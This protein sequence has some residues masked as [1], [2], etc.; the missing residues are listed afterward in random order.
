MGKLIQFIFVI[1]HFNI[2]VCSS[3]MNTGHLCRSDQSQFL[4]RLK[5]RINID[6]TASLDCDSNGKP[7]YPKTIS[8]NRSTDCCR[9][10]GVTCNALSGEVIGLDLSCSQ[11]QGVI[12]SNS[13]L[14][15]LSHLQRLNLAY[16]D[17]SSSLIS[18]KFGGLVSLTH[19][20]LSSSGFSG[21]LPSQFL[22]LSHL[23]SLDL[24]LPSQNI[25]I[26]PTVF[27]L[28][29]QN[30]TQLREVLLTGID[31]ASV[32]PSNLSASLAALKLGSTNLYGKCPADI[33]QL[34]NLLR[35]E[36]HSNFDLSGYLS[37]VK[38]NR[39][40]AL[41]YLDLSGTAF[42]G[43][44][45]ESIGHLKSLNNLDLSFCNFWGPIPESLANLTQMDYLLLFGNN[46]SGQVPSRLG[47]LKQLIRLDLST[48]SL[49]GQMPNFFSSFNNLQELSLS[50]NY[51]IGSFP[52]SVINLTQ[53]KGLDL[54]NNSLTGPIPSNITGLQNLVLLLLGSNLLSGAAPS[55]AFSLPSLIYLDL[56]LNQLTGQLYDFQYQPLQRIYL[57]GNQ[58]D[59]PVPKSI[60]KLVNLTLLDLS[61]N[62]FSGVLDA[63]MFSNCNQLGTLDLSD[64][65]LLLT[66]D[67]VNSSLPQ[68]LAYLFLSS[69]GIKDLDFLMPVNS[70]YRLDLSKN[71]LRGQLFSD[72]KWSNW[73]QH[74]YYLNLS[75][76]FLIDVRQ[77]PFQNLV[78]LDLSS[79]LLQGPLLIP[80][81]TTSVFVI[82]DNNLTGAIPSTICTLS[83]LVILDLSNNNF[84]GVIPLCLG[85]MSM[86]LSVLDMHKNR[87]HGNIPLIFSVGSKLRSLNLRD[88]RLE[89]AVPRSLSNCQELEV[90]DMGNNFLNGTFPWWLGN[91][92]HLRVLSLRSNNLGGPVSTPRAQLGSFSALRILDL[93]QN[94]FT[95]VLPARIFSQLNDMKTINGATRLKYLGDIMY[96]DSV[97]LVVKG[98]EINLV[99][100]LTIFT[101]ID[102][103]SNKFEG[104]IP[105]VIGDLKS[106]RGL[107]F[108]H[109]NL[110]G[111][112]PQVLG[113]LTILESLDLSSNQLVGEIPQQLTALTY[114]S[115]L[116]LSQNHLVG[117]IPRGKQF[118]T[119]QNNSY[120]GNRALCGFPLSK[121]CNANELPQ[122]QS[123]PPSLDEEDNEEL[124]SGFTWSAVLIG[125]GCGMV[126]G[127][128]TGCLIFYTGRPK[129]FCKIV[130]RESSKL[131]KKKRPK[132]VK[133]L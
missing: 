39:C 26:Q 40:S 72:Q 2:A 117:S 114:L 32:I 93:S 94:D 100:I 73:S 65:N 88:N 10:D 50:S 112:I 11:L 15:Q 53:L 109:N 83:S 132:Y 18:S 19:L 6:H 29:L 98:H 25:R 9:W 89:G 7:S 108:S 17:F 74:L 102:L 49:E 105:D 97:V 5:Q 12:N 124:V 104:Q 13:S 82:S 58:M 4:L 77:L 121:S 120:M 31:I 22:R 23:I 61:S 130:Q 51:F 56:Q 41:S 1:L 67:G 128:I 16:N 101:T 106:L 59:G 92:P 110:A 21:Q 78:Y 118:D 62:N 122:Q 76:N 87:F 30:L 133:W 107:N 52:S 119:F 68:S 86:E 44:L 75:N 57:S 127:V 38:W 66:T 64:N 8:W 43:E 47:N 55:W 71:M 34:P 36:L 42:S 63:S 28:L 99:R 81:V 80:P 45:S 70:L 69:C 103:S 20:N 24:S 84:S 126:T 37:D 125:Y 33:F 116:N 113:N 48:N 79:S 123:Q 3:P 54:A 111:Q 96:R 14:F 27:K 91:L 129:W 131:V 35:L 46:F 95:G 90:L 85:N 60:S 115:V